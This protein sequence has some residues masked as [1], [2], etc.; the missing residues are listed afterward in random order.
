MRLV[1]THGAAEAAGQ[2]SVQL[3][4]EDGRVRAIEFTCSCGDV[5]AVEL[6]YPGES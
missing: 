3:L 2:K 5:T 6:T 1:H 4:E